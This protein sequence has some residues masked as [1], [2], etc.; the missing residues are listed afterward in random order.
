[1]SE[2]ER[3]K[4]LAATSLLDS[5]SE[6]RFNRLVRLASNALGTEVALISLLDEERQWFKAKLG[7]DASQTSRE[8]AFCHHAIQKPNEVMVV[9]DASQDTRFRDNPLVTGGPNIAFYAGAPLVTKSGHALGTLCVIDSKPRENFGVQ[10]QQILRD[11]ALSVMT[12]IELSNQNQISSDLKLINDELQHRMGNMYAHIAGLVSML[13]RSDI[14]KDQLVRRI[15]EKITAL[16]QTQALLA[17]NNYESIPFTELVASALTPFRDAHNADR[18]NIQSDNDFHVSPRGAFI[19]TLMINELGTNAMK[20]GALKSESGSVDF[21]WTV[22][23]K[24]SFKWDERGLEPQVDFSNQKGFGSQ[25]LKRI[26]P[27][28][29]QGDAELKILGESL[30]YK[31][32]AMPDRVYAENNCQIT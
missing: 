8:H 14:N 13:G 26:V 10:D 21:T 31:V 7:V 15:R 4:A 23:K 9:S 11:L 19:L 6:E 20:H 25:I 29:L 30:L 3:L 18:V 5:E 17:C 28:D 32:S 24:L 16:S 22:G 1:M 2:S 12:E 27:M